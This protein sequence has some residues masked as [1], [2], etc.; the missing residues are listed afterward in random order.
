MDGPL[1]DE[2]APIMG[3]KIKLKTTNLTLQEAIKSKLPYKRKNWDQN[4]W[5]EPERTFIGFT[6]DEV[7]AEDWMINVEQ[8]ENTIK[9]RQKLNELTKYLLPLQSIEEVQTFRGALFNFD[10]FLWEKAKKEPK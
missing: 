5:I 10:K 1:T 6:I 9:L 7:L 4:C 3:D 8:L 2:V